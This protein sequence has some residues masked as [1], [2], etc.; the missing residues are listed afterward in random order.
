FNSVG[1]SR[2][3]VSSVSGPSLLPSIKYLL[4]QNSVQ[5]EEIIKLIKLM[6][7]TS[8]YSNES[9]S[10]E[11]SEVENRA[12]RER[13]LQSQ[14]IQMQQRIGGLVEELQRIKAQNAQLERRL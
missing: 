9:V 7:Q 11:V 6:E 5:R 14:A 8:G 12:M 4:Q 10:S 13:E 2:Q 1:P 3:M